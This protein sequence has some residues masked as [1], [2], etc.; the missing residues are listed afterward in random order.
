[1][2]DLTD[3]PLAERAKRYRQLARD[4]A[5]YASAG[6]PTKQSYIVMSEQWEKMA[7]EAE[8]LLAKAKEEPK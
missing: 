5:R 7:V 6:G 8:A 1:M 4:A 2:T 3:L